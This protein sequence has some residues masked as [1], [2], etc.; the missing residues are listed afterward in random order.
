M[1]DR[2][3]CLVIWA[4]E[5][6]FRVRDCVRTLFT[7][8]PIK[9]SVVI[10]CQSV[11][12][13]FV[14]AMK[15]LNTLYSDLGLRVVFWPKERINS[16][17]IPRNTNDIFRTASEDY[18]SWTHDDV[19]FTP[20]ERLLWEEL[21]CIAEDP[22]VGLVSCCSNGAEGLQSLRRFNIPEVVVAGNIHM[23]LALINEQ[24]FRD[25]GGLC[26][27]PLE[28][29]AGEVDLSLRLNYLGYINV[30]NRRL[31]VH[32]EIGTTNKSHFS[33]IQDYKNWLQGIW[34]YQWNYLIHSYG[35]KAYISMSKLDMEDDTIELLFGEFGQ[36]EMSRQKSLYIPKCYNKKEVIENNVRR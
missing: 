16:K 24:V 29:P 2:T 19:L 12:P 18:F 10:S 8:A 28:F 17:N 11:E 15:D 30:V 36:E 9:G 3:V 5:D 14:S 23:P 27:L 35:L 1:T 34:E 20:N 33:S 32:H 25:L 26:E 4:S 13:Y 6:A 21:T 7:H 31:Y 22:S